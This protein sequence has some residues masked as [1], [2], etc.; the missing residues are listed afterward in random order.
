M[1]T[2]KLALVSFNERVYRV[3]TASAEHVGN[4]QHSN[5]QWKFKAVGSDL[6]GEILPGWGPLTD[7]HNTVVASPDEE[8][9][10]EL[11]SEPCLQ[12]SL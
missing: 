6:D 5:G 11:L 9:L 2:Y 10:N 8:L 7:W 4:L 3:L 1:I 12:K